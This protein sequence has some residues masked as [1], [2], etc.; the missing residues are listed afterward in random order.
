[1]LSEARAW[2]GATAEAFGLAEDACFDVQLAVS[3]AVTNAVIHGSASP[4]DPVDLEAREEG[5]LLVF[6][7]RDAGNKPRRE[8]SFERV[9]EG[10]RGLALMAL[11]MDDVLLSCSEGGGLLR[12]AKR[13]TG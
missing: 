5:E 8:D 1:M 11:V 3:E 7:V 12:F 10:G 4:T 6:E 9:A 2:A 13:R